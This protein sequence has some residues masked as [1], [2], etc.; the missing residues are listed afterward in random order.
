MPIHPM[1]RFAILLIGICA[2]FWASAAFAQNV[3]SYGT[4]LISEQQTEL[5]RL[6]TIIDDLSRKVS[7]SAEDDARLVELRTELEAVSQAVLKSGLAF[8][9]R[10]AEINTRLDLVKEELAHGLEQLG[11]APGDGQPPEPDIVAGERQNLVSEKAEINVLLGI[12]ENLSVRIK[13]LIDDIAEMRRDL[14]ARLLTKRYA[15]DY[16]LDGVLRRDGRLLSHGGVL[17]AL[18]LPIQ[19]EVGHRG[20]VLRPRSGGHPGHRRPAPSRRPV[21]RRSDTDT[22][23][24]S[25]LPVGGL[26]VDAAALGGARRVPRGDLSVLRLLQRVARRHRRDAALAVLRH[27]RSLLRPQAGARR[28]RAAAAGMEAHSRRAQRRAAPCPARLGDG[29]LHRRRSFPDQRVRRCR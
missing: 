26:L 18:R 24:L 2:L 11:P 25:R 15:I 19:T 29:V 12:A 23:V 1:R 13:R 22:A 28:T 6:S 5:D 3:G 7:A 14:F 9:P 20:D 27:R 8:R 4:G 21:R 16:A 10:L 17:A